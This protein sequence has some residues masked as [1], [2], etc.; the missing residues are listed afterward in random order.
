VT[1]AVAEAMVED[2]RVVQ[3]SSNRS[4][5][6]NS[7]KTEKSSFLITIK[8]DDIDKTINNYEDKEE[9]TV[10]INT[11]FEV[12]MPDIPGLPK[13]S[14]LTYSMVKV[15]PALKPSLSFKNFDMSYPTKEAVSKAI[16][17]AKKSP[18]AIVR[19]LAM[20][21]GK[22]ENTEAANDLKD[23]D[24][25][26]GVAFDVVIENKTKAKMTFKSM[27]YEVKLGGSEFIKGFSVDIKNSGSLSVMRV[28]NELNTR[29]LHRALIIAYFSSDRNFDLNGKAEMI[30]PESISAEPVVFNF[31]EK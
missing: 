29:A 25:T 12:A 10:T 8:Y 31:N 26:F 4:F 22:G 27:D 11:L 3:T 30:F 7:G 13:K 15:I 17:K 1:K 9:I 14:L 28:K 21:A 2:R 6:I 24:L 23:V 20:F 5:Y 19:I 18:L 16:I